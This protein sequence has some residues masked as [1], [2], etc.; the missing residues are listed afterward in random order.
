MPHLLNTLDY[1]VFI[2]ALIITKST[3]CVVT[4]FFG[5]SIYTLECKLQR[6]GTLSVILTTVP[7]TL[8]LV[9]STEQ[10]LTYLWNEQTRYTDQI[11]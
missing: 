9:P 5:I 4:Y 1:T 6:R 2:T 3:Q 7:L 11:S 10:M 8:R